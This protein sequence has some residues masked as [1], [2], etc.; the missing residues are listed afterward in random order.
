M[1]VASH[2]RS[3]RV[4][5]H[6]KP[7]DNASLASAPKA[8]NGT[9]GHRPTRSFDDNQW[10]VIAD[11]KTWHIELADDVK[12]KVAFT[13]SHF[14]SPGDK[15]AVQGEM[16]HGKPGICTATGVQVTLAKPL[17]ASK[18]AKRHKSEAE[19]VPPSDK[20]D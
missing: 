5:R 17:S 3:T 8:G 1:T 4:R 9:D 16:I 19:A 15:I 11:G 2:N 18:D 6:S 10:S 13:G 7:A 14:V 20:K 12:I